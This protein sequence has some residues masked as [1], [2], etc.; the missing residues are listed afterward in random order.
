[1][2]SH[3]R[4]LRELVNA[5]PIAVLPGVFDAMS[6]LLARAAGFSALYLSGSAVV[7]SQLGLPDHGLITLTEMAGQARRIVLATGLPLVSDAD[8]GFGGALNAR[9]T[10][11]EFEAAGA[12]G[13]HIEDQAFPKRCG[14]L[15]GK[16]LVSPADMATKIKA[17]VA[18]R[19]DPDF[20]VIGRVD[21]RGPLG[22]DEAVRRG[23]L[24]LEAGADMIFPEALATAEEFAA[25]AREVRGPLLANMT[26]FGKTPLFEARQFESWGFAAVIFPVSALRVAM[27]AMRDFY[28][29]LK[30]TGSQKSTLETMLTR[31]DLYALT[32]YRDLLAWEKSLAESSGD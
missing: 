4:T 12:A 23:R 8:T 13:I 10:V 1:M 20:M 16:E 31:D 6:G 14:H 3:A 22:F 15:E 9:R 17:A 2:I 11:A 30:A 28:R 21:A 27:A 18:A 29:E 7:N 19:R 25:Y 26:E 5:A 32:G 24:Y